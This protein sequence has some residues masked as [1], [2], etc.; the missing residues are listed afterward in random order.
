MQTEKKKKKKAGVA[1]LRTDKIRVT[2]TWEV[3][4]VSQEIFMEIIFLLQY[5]S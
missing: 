3:L 1:I 4:R 2:N 5:K